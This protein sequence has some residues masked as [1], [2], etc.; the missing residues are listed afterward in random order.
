ML[1]VFIVAHSQTKTGAKKKLLTLGNWH[2][3]F[4]GF[5]KQSSSNLKEEQYNFYARVT[6]LVK[7]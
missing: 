7:K 6:H 1:I 3:H 5:D 2:I 4:S